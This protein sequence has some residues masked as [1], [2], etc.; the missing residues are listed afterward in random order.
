LMSINIFP[1]LI[2]MLLA[3]NF[4]DAQARSKQSEAIALTI[5]TLGLAFVS[6]LLFRW[7]FLQKFALT[8]PELLIITTVI[9]NIAI[10]RFA[11]LR[12]KEWFRFRSLIEEE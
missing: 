12:L 3:E 5:E 1:I 8:E 11:G 9:I 7:E 4:L 2:L 10:G 6:S